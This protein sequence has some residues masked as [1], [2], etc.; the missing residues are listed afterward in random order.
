MLTTLTLRLAALGLVRTDDDYTS[1]A[2][3]LTPVHCLLHK[4][5]RDRIVAGPVPDSL[6]AGR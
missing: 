3:S 1:A 5:V 4:Y 2:S 6:R